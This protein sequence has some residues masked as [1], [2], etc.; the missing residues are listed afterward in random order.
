MTSTFNGKKAHVLGIIITVA[1]AVPA[2]ALEMNPE[3]KAVVEGAASEHKFTLESPAVLMGGGDGVKAFVAWMSREFDITVA[4]QWN[5]NPSFRTLIGKIVTEKQAGQ[6]SSSDVYMGTAVQVQP[7]LT[8]GIFRQVAWTKL[9]PGR[10]TPEIAEADGLAL[11]VS[12]RFPGILYNKQTF[13]EI[14]K[15]GSLNDLLQPEFKGKFST[16]P[17]LAGFDVLI[18]NRGYEKAAD[19]LTKFVTQLAGVVPCG[20]G[21][22]IASGE[23]QALVLDCAGTEQNQPRFK[24]YLA[25]YIVPDAAQRRYNYLTIPVNAA[26]PNTGILYGVFLSTE[27]GQKW[28]RDRDGTDLDTYSDSPQHQKAIDM[29]A[30]GVK[31][32]DVTLSWEGEHPK[33]PDQLGDLTK[34]LRQK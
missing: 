10:V 5:P 12:T 19:Y 22:R 8:S 16:N 9:L 6:E 7:V 32:T 20:S 24:D 21:E 26:H 29:Q 2:S 4:S 15:I 3:L 33:A 30:Q 1:T 27:E 18:G 13:P 14:G 31:F 17:D 25:L 34:L 28:N 11:R 23:V